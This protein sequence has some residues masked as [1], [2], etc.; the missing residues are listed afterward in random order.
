MLKHVS[1][2]GKS[3]GQKKTVPSDE[4]PVLNYDI[5]SKATK[6]QLQALLIKEYGKVGIGTFG[7]GPV[8]NHAAHKPSIAKVIIEICMA[9]GPKPDEIIKLFSDE[10]SEN[11]KVITGGVAV[12]LAN[13]NIKQ[14]IRGAR[15]DPSVIATRESIHSEVSIK[16]TEWIKEG[17]KLNN[18]NVNMYGYVHSKCE[19][20]LKQELTKE[21]E[22]ESIMEANDGVQLTLLI[23]KILSVST[24]KH[25]NLAKSD[26]ERFYNL[27]VQ[28]K[29]ETVHEFYARY[30]ESLVR[31]NAA[32]LDDISAVDQ[33]RHFLD[34]LD[35]ERFGTALAHLHNETSSNPD[36]Y[37]TTVEGAYA[38]AHSKVIYKQPK[39]S[40]DGSSAPM[41]SLAGTADVAKDG[42]KD[43]SNITCYHCQKKGH[44]KN[45]CPLIK[46][47]KTAADVPKISTTPAGASTVGAA[48]E[49]EG[50]KKKKNRKKKNKSSAAI[51]SA[52]SDGFFMSFPAIRMRWGV[53]DHAPA[54]LDDDGYPVEEVTRALDA[55]RALN[56][57]SEQLLDRMRA[58]IIDSGSE[59]HM[60]PNPNLP[61]LRELTDVP[62]ASV[63]GVGDS[64]RVN[65]RG[66][67]IDVG[68][69][70]YTPQAPCTIIS[71]GLS[72]A[73]GAT[74]NWAADGSEV[75]LRTASGLRIVFKRRRHL[76]VCEDFEHLRDFKPNVD[77]DVDPSAS[78]GFV[79]AP[80]TQE[81]RRMKYSESDARAADATGN[82][83]RILGFP[84]PKTASVLAKFGHIKN[85]GI[86]QKSLRHRFDIVGSELEFAKGSRNKRHIRP[87]AEVI[88]EDL[89]EEL[90]HT[91]LF[92]DLFF[93]NRLIFLVGAAYLPY[94]ARPLYLQCHMPSKST[95]AITAA[96]KG[97]VGILTSQRVEVLSIK[98]D[99]EPSLA[100]AKSTIESTLKI[101]VDL[102]TD[103]V[104]EAER[105]VG[106]IKSVCRRL[107][108]GLPLRSFLL[109]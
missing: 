55:M 13:A 74:V 41:V 49:D 79:A 108:A 106:V 12:L 76:W 58:I 84:G 10:N 6:D 50:N 24:T 92:I 105:G 9:G 82:M 94:C 40:S 86:T 22:F 3:D 11:V 65:R 95:T 63:I 100:A 97:F 96:V 85:V 5:I 104:A 102:S 109:C 23:A 103:N 81:E 14:R 98:S 83:L 27:L 51:S 42:K 34:R 56:G 7:T 53:D 33:A 67:F 25:P 16:L 20:R 70:Y 54:L 43:P 68:N 44:F 66:A 29:T 4:F 62:A 47:K 52:A 107:K 71:L 80:V 31:R 35:M 99:Q 89:L 93:L 90:R 46:V 38:W 59:V 61:G 77:E 88:N 36:A 64:V 2:R 1:P 78:P 45:N 8:Y 28:S 73:K 60:S 69:M 72:L 15:T 19:E 87:A 32:R 39:Q 26:A 21:A 75:V 18:I 101:K 17:T 37:P 30:L 57:A 91:N 48:K